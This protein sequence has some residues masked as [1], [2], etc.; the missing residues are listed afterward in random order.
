MGD[1][2]KEAEAKLKGM[3]KKEEVGA[4]IVGALAAGAVAYEVYEHEKKKKE[5]EQGADGQQQQE[6]HHFHHKDEKTQ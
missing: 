4:G 6:H 5:G 3:S 1:F 2:L